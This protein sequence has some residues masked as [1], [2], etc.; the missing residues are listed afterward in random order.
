MWFKRVVKVLKMSRAELHIWDKELIEGKKAKEKL[1][2]IKKDNKNLQNL[3]DEMHVKSLELQ[4]ELQSGPINGSM[5][6][7]QEM[8][9]F[10]KKEN[11][12][13]LELGGLSFEFNNSAF[14][15]EEERTTPEVKT[16]TKE[17]KEV[18]DKKDYDD[19]LFHSS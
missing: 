16:M 2:T 9:R 11:V 10:A 18:Q 8:I 15:K 12:S 17:E 5:K 13:K 1:D 19:L 6:Q 4:D 14:I 7:V 3:V